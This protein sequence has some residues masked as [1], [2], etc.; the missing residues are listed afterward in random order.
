MT[1][2]MEVFGSVPVFGVVAA[3]YVAAFE[4][5]SE[6]YPGVTSFN[7]LFTDMSAGVGNFDLIQ[8]R[9]V[10][11]WR[12]SL[13]DVGSHDV[14]VAVGRRQM[15]GGR[16]RRQP[17]EERVLMRPIAGNLLPRLQL[18]IVPGLLNHVA[19]LVA[20]FHQTSVVAIR[21]FR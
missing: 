20:R 15:S 17:T 4:A 3:A 18:E 11:H 7:A 9:T 5:E 14:G 16:A 13:I 10:G 19:F 2:V 21:N 1:S 6:M 8:V 12:S